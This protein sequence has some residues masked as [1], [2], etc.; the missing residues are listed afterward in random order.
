MVSSNML[1]AQFT[2]AAI[3]CR[4]N[5]SLHSTYFVTSD[6]RTQNAQ[7]PLDSVSFRIMCA[8]SLRVL[9]C[10]ARVQ[11]RSLLVRQSLD[12]CR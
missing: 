3:H 4:C 11:F 8:I 6:R 10:L 1:S 12:P 5:A 7:P 2:V 9:C